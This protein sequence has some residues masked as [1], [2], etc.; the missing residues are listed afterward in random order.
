MPPK[1]NDKTLDR[2]CEFGMLLNRLD[3]NDE[4]LNLVVTY[5]SKISNLEKVA[6]TLFENDNIKTRSLKGWLE[7]ELNLFSAEKEILKQIARKGNFIVDYDRNGLVSFPLYAAKEVIGFLHVSPNPGTKKFSKGKLKLLALLSSQIAPSMGILLNNNKGQNSYIEMIMIETLARAIEAKDP[8]TKGHSDRVAGY[9]TS[10]AMELRL[11]EEQIFAIRH[12][13]LL[14]DIGK[15]GI[16]EGILT[17]EGALNFAEFDAVKMHPLI[18]ERIITP[19]K[20]FKDAIPMVLYHHEHFDGTGYLEGLKGEDIPLGARILTVADA[21]DAMISNR[22]YRPAINKEQ[23][24]NELQKQS[25]LQFD[26]KIVKM[27]MQIAN[28]T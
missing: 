18:G 17:K 1:K 14:H 26:P 2:L 9:A 10:I 24:L 8:Y 19:I 6:I 12:M 21:Y 16:K 5:V 28:R 13:G 25:G 3:K 4:A 15:I 27:F 20:I 7:Q 22:P 23:A 11:P